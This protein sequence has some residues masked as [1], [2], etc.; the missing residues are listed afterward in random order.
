MCA[1]SIQR[2]YPPYN[3]Q[4]NTPS[5]A[6]GRVHC[7]AENAAAARGAE[8]DGVEHLEVP[9]QHARHGS[10]GAASSLLSQRKSK[11]QHARNRRSASADLRSVGKGRVA[12]EPICASS[13]AAPGNGEAEFA[14]FTSDRNNALR[15]LPWDSKLFFPQCVRIMRPLWG[16]WGPVLTSSRTPPVAGAFEPQGLRRYSGS[17]D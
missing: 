14:A 12:R 17:N 13:R 5:S 6:F 16:L 7:A 2:A 4:H 9:R 10:T 11:E 15:A 1:L 3:L 8:R